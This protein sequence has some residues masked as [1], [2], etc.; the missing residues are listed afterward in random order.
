MKVV[1]RN[2]KLLAIAQYE[3]NSNFWEADLTEA[4]DFDDEKSKAEVTLAIDH[5][6]SNHH[7]DFERIWSNLRY[8][9][10]DVYMRSGK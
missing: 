2:G 3:N 8:S 6:M 9:L 10:V 5:W 1:Y 4:L 7:E